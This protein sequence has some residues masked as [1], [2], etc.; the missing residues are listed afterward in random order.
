K[1]KQHYDAGVTHSLKN[2]VGIVPKSYYE[3]PYD[4]SRRAKLHD[5]GGD[6]MTHLPRSICDLNL[7]RPVH[8]AVIDGIKNAE[9]GEGTWNPTFQIAEY[10]VLLAGKDP[11]ATDSV[12]SYLMGNDPEAEKF[13]LPDGVRQCDNY[14]ELLHQKGMGTNQMAEIEIKGDGA[15]LVT[16]RLNLNMRIIFLNTINFFRIIPTLLILPRPYH[17][18]CPGRNMLL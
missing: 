10:D 6:M 5:D 15:G 12:A 18:M 1:M 11:V 16:L 7:T 14:L 2:Q 9:G 8:L 17:F 3:L 4:H 13:Q